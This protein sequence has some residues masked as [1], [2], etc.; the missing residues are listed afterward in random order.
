MKERLQP[1]TEDTRIICRNYLY[2][3]EIYPPY[4][5]PG[6]CSTSLS[7]LLQSASSGAG[8]GADRLGGIGEGFESL[9]SLVVNVIQLM[10]YI[11]SEINR[12]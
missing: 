6:T 9:E 2:N 3:Q 11:D 7:C 5:N 1:C 10:H 4:A 12:W 8:E